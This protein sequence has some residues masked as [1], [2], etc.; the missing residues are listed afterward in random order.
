MVP[1]SVSP[2]RSQAK[3]FPNRCPLPPP[4]TK[5]SAKSPSFASSSNS[6]VSLS[7]RTPRSAACGQ[8]RMSPQ[9]SRKKNGGSDPP[10]GRARS[11]PTSADHFHRP[12]QDRPPRSGSAGNGRTLVHAPRGRGSLDWRNSI[13]P[14]RSRSS[15]SITRV[16]IYGNWFANSTPMTKSARKPGYGPTR[17]ACWTRGKLKNW[18]PPS[19]PSTPPTPN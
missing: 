4:S 9:P 13:S 6:V 5:P 7:R 10:G 12:A 11:R 19:A 8:L 17:N 16:S 15:T 1:I 18:W 14:A 3:A 2:T